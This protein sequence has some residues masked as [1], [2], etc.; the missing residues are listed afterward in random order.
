MGGSEPS[1]SRELEYM[2]NPRCCRLPSFT[3]DKP[4]ARSELD[5]SITY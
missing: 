3:S 5:L 2:I 1:F 4:H